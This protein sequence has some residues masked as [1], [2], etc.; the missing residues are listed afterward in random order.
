MFYK[1]HHIFNAKLHRYTIVATLEITKQEYLEAAETAIVADAFYSY[2]KIGAQVDNLRF[3]G[4]VTEKSVDNTEPLTPEEVDA[5]L[6]Q[7]GYDPDVVGEY[8]QAVA[9]AA[10]IARQLGLS[11]ES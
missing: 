3:D 10:I 7:A 9:D 5:A 6:R 11:G 8:F 4:T 2:H 1:I